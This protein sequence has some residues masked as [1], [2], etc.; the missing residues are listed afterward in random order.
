MTSVTNN[1]VAA[2]ICMS[3]LNVFIDT[4]VLLRFYAFTSDNLDEAA[5]LSA[6]IET[7]QIKVF[8]TEQVVDEFYRQRDRELG[9]SMRSF[10]NGAINEQTPRF[11][12]GYEELQAYRKATKNLKDARKA[13]L[14]K[15]RDDLS[16]QNLRA[17]L[18][19][20]DIF[21]R[22]GVFVRGI[23]IVEASRLRRELCNPPGK[24]G[25][26]S[27]GDQINWE[28]L[29]KHVPNKE[30]IHIISRDGD[31]GD[32]EK[33]AGVSS[34]LQ[35][36]WRRKKEAKVYLYAGLAEFT[37]E[38]FENIKLPSD[39]K[40]LVAINSLVVSA[41]F[42]ETHKQIALLDGIFSDITPDDSVVIL[43]AFIENVQ[44]GGIWADADVSN[45]YSK[46]YNSF[47]R[48]TSVDLDRDLWAHPGAEL[49]SPF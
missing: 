8:V 36:E 13:L 47:M 40:R 25:Q 46:L 5:K 19:T 49:F 2:E 43:R 48:H 30:D 20:A 28:I 45:F 29:L 15:V 10:E 21:K 38:H 16:N 34:F 22:S 4:N 35:T 1:T 9:S 6:L 33:V 39:A 18:L 17:D 41:S 44:I 31:F 23:E 11:M 12:D 32:G 3:S 37:K 14:D 7:R 42:A 27:I 24:E 26:R